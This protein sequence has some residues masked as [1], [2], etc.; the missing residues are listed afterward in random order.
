MQRDTHF[1]LFLAFNDNRSLWI[2]AF[3]SLENKMAFAEK[4]NKWEIKT[5]KGC[6]T[7]IQSAFFHSCKKMWSLLKL[8]SSQLFSY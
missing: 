4:K 1:T 7:A 8:V 2:A 3:G 5:Q 6:V